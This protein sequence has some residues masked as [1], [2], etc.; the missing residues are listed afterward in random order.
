[1]EHN[2][3]ELGGAKNNTNVDL[4]AGELGWANKN[5]NMEHNMSRVDNILDANGANN[6]EKEAKVCESN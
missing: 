4:D 5:S 6:A 1:M 2:A 3:S